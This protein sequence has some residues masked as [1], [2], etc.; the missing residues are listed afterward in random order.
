MD[1]ILE[2]SDYQI[3]TKIYESQGALIYRGRR[4][5][6]DKPVILKIARTRNVEEI[7]RYMQEHTMM[8]RLHALG[9]TGPCWLEKQETHLVLVCEDFGG[10]SL[11]KI[12]MGQQLEIR[13]LIQIFLKIVKNLG[14]IH[15]ADIV[16]KD[17]KPSNIIY[18]PE[19]GHLEIVDFGIST[20][21]PRENPSIENPDLPNGSLHYISPEQTGRMNRSLDYRTDFYS[22]GASLYAL[23]SG[24]VPFQ[25]RDS[26]EVIHAHIAKQPVL[27]HELD[28]GISKSLSML[29]DKL[30]SKNADDRYKSCIGIAKDLE[31]CLDRLED[32]GKI[33]PFLL[34]THDIT[35]KFQMSQ[36]LYERQQENR[37]LLNAFE[38]VVQ[39]GK[40]SILISGYSGS[41]KTTLVRE[42][43]KP[44]TETRGYFIGGKF[45]QLQRNIPYSAMFDAFSSL[46]RQ[47]LS[48]S[49]ERIS[50]RKDQLIT[51]LSPYA[52]LIIDA[53]PELELITGKQPSV[54]ELGTVE[55]Q[56]RFNLVFQLLIRAC[57]DPGR[58]LTIFLDDMQWA[59]HSTLKLLEHIT[60]NQEIQYLFFIGAYRDNEVSPTH[61][62]MMTLDEIRKKNGPL[63]TIHLGPLSSGNVNEMAADTLQCPLESAAP[64]AELVVKKT[65]GNPFF[66]NQF[67][68]LLYDENAL[69][70]NYKKNKWE[71]DLRLIEAMGIT[72]NVVDLMLRKLRKLPGE[73]RKLLCMAA[74]VGNR[75][76]LHT[77][78]VI[79][80][81]EPV[82]IYRILLPVEQVGLVQP[83]SQLESADIE[84]I[85]SPLVI[86]NHRFLHDRVQE[87][88]YT[89][90]PEAQRAEVHLKIG[91]LMLKDAQSPVEDDLFD[92]V[93]HLN[94]GSG[95]ITENEER[96]GLARLNLQAAQKAKASNAYE[97]ALAYT[98]QGLCL[99]PGEDMWKTH[100]HLALELNIVR[101]D[102]E[103]F[104]GNFREAEKIFAHTLSYI[105]DDI[106]KSRIYERQLQVHISNNRMEDALALTS[107]VLN[108]WGLD[109]QT[110][111]SREKWLQEDA[112]YRKALGNRAISDLIDL[113]EIDNP[114][115]E[116]ALHLLM[117]SLPPSYQT[118]SKR[119]YCMITL[120]TTMMNIGLKYGH[121]DIS[122]YAYAAYTYCITD[123][124]RYEEAYAYGKLAMV[125]NEKIHNFAIKGKLYIYF[126]FHAQFWR[127][128]FSKCE[129]FWKESYTAALEAGDLIHVAFLFLNKVPLRTA[130]SINLHDLARETEKAI[131]IT[132][133]T[134]YE[135]MLYII[136][137]DFHLIKN[138]MGTTHGRCSLDSDEFS[139]KEYIDFMTAQNNSMGFAYY[140]AA[141]LMTYY[142]FGQYTDAVAAGEAFE[143]NMLSVPGMAVL[144]EHGFYFPLAITALYPTMDEKKKKKYRKI[145]NQYVEKAR[146][147]AENCPDNFLNRYLLIQ[148]ET[149]RIDGNGPEAVRLYEEAA[150]SA[151]ANA[152]TNNEALA[153]ELAAR[154]W[155]EQ[156][157]KRYARIHLEDALL[158]YRLWGANAKITELSEKYP[159]LINENSDHADNPR[160][161]SPAL[162]TGITGT[163]LDLTAPH[164]LDL[165]TV[166]KANQAISREIVLERLLNKLMEIVL[167]NAGAQM[168]MLIMKSGK[169]Y[170]IE[171]QANIDR[172]RQTCKYSIM[173]QDTHEKNSSV[174][175]LSIIR[176]ADHTGKPVLLNDASLDHDFSDDPYIAQNRPLSVLCLPM[177]QQRKLVGILY[178]ENN[179]SP[180]VFT[181][182]RVELLTILSSQVAISLEN[183]RLY[184]KIEEYTQ[185]LEE[186]V[187]DRTAK[188][189]EANN[190]LKNLANQDGLTGTANR[191]RFD[192]YLELSWMRLKRAQKPISVIMIDIDY[193][194]FYN[195]TYGH[196][197]GDDCLSHVTKAI[198]REV[199]RSVDMVARYG[200]EEFAV[201]LP[202][203]DIQGALKVAES[204][205]LSIT[206]L[207]IPHSGSKA[208]KYVSISAGVS[209]MVPALSGNSTEMLI[210]HADKAL[211]KA[212]KHGRNCVFPT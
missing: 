184:Q 67:L 105:K 90:I 9:V 94:M 211:Y 99:L 32:T 209:S 85:D 4:K 78:S 79:Y 68:K 61:P 113:P 51:A 185:T 194:K 119:P 13:E 134:N 188:L 155:L 43:Y 15:A 26:M 82:D 171:I 154:Y 29:V 11:D 16:H 3:N 47:F 135:L 158:G 44:I 95:L 34:G 132:E 88:A 182:D 21:L 30:L 55:A 204:I 18:N 77:L 163:T 124:H 168:G 109:V 129:P 186:K 206:N 162:T 7:V 121:S 112:K 128:H 84:K 176:Y 100:Y 137:M 60:T 197:R 169:E 187:A 1:F 53:I 126:T 56:N 42:I 164:A 19:T 23:L 14:K 75:F 70:F 103:V 180:G 148:A 195:D 147:W 110:D 177:I 208:G 91:R 192:E 120:M 104:E 136:R 122:A 210:R 159:Q 86:K 49:P 62:L 146:I 65:D 39:G 118:R 114:K 101:S 2:F 149:A 24:Q 170:W 37:I 212:K 83:I 161:T 36:K 45:D 12:V 72:S 8:C 89:M 52:Q 200:G 64:L 40:E 191:R 138:F 141:K 6:D 143:K 117:N 207:K 97:T 167:E 76:D 71:W 157:R 73:I 116:A 31:E 133:K 46:I 198:C 160:K 80:E 203:T 199:K 48:E 27:L 166:I 92:I 28:P 69:V 173:S 151:H 10:D 178:L 205:R 179:L 190:K 20:L 87:A 131:R 127:E 125:L 50:E 5:R 172:N 93:N 22:L 193:F 181:P 183:S 59:D 96:V 108:R 57:C 98:K 102:C 145:L 63:E 189:R 144:A 66:V 74:C 111:P 202:E 175:P 81:K 54:P 152:F 150:Q 123:N 142:L 33:A 153:N 38:Q 165:G 139:E 156:G 130:Q 35:D 174:L 140:H 196:P 58:P 17:I 115:M 201:I 106:E 25:T 107:R 41:G